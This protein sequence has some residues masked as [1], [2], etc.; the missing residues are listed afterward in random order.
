MTVSGVVD[1]SNRVD[2]TGVDQR[3]AAQA[4]MIDDLV[5]D[6]TANPAIEELLNAAEALELNYKV[7]REL[8]HRSLAGGSAAP[9]I[10]LA[11]DSGMVG[12][13]PDPALSQVVMS[14]VREAMEFQLVGNLVKIRQ[15]V[16]LLL[17]SAT[18]PSEKDHEFATGPTGEPTPS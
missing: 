13:H 6:S 7:I 17:A 10:R 2:P 16:D 11:F 3:L 12:F 8:A 9:E 4:D 5:D 1:D 15:L 18:T 14:Q